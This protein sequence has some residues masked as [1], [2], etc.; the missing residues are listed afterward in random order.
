MELFK[1]NLRL[2]D[3]ES[4][5]TDTSDAGSMTESQREQNHQRVKSLRSE[6]N[7][8]G[9]EASRIRVLD[10]QWNEADILEGKSY[11]QIKAEEKSLEQQISEYRNRIT[12]MMNSVSYFDDDEKKKQVQE[13]RKQIEEK[14]DALDKKLDILKK[15]AYTVKM[16]EA[17]TAVPEDMKQWFYKNAEAKQ[18]VDALDSPF[19]IIPAGKTLIENRVLFR[20]SLMRSKSSE[21]NIKV[22]L[23]SWTQSAETE[24]DFMIRAQNELS[25]HWMLMRAA[26]CALHLMSY[27]TILKR[28]TQKMRRRFALL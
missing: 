12:E 15:N 7:R 1:I 6:L 11:A 13:E 16:E 19:D 25:L 27:I 24:T 23:K 21:E 9:S 22:R 4:G 8:L 14:V 28:K 10:E 3:G 17:V 5:G 18:T 2:F 26:L 20:H